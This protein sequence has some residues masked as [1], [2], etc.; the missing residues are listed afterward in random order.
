MI[1]QNNIFYERADENALKKLEFKKD[2]KLINISHIL[3]NSD[4]WP[5]TLAYVGFVLV[6]KGFLLGSGHYWQFL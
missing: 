5:L 6:D 1:C 4:I 2:D 3:L